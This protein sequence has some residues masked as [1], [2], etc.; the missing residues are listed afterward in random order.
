MLKEGLVHYYKLN[1]G[2]PGPWV[3][4]VAGA[5]LV[6][7]TG[8]AVGNRAGH[9][10]NGVEFNG[11]VGPQ[12]LQSSAA[13]THSTGMTVAA[14]IWLD[15]RAYINLICQKGNGW[16]F[17]GKDSGAGYKIQ[18]ASKGNSIT[19]VSPTTLDLNKWYHVV[20]IYGGP[21]YSGHH[22][23]WIDGIVNKEYQYHSHYP[24]PDNSGLC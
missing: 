22:D 8:V 3:D 18:F 17:Y 9:F 10:G 1:E 2:H 21:D 13:L 5:N 12:Q 14:W 19:V 24:I 6:Q 11:S 15:S 7:S 23:I 16:S 4:T 20:G